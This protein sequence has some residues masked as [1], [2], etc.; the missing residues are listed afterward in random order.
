MSLAHSPAAC[1]ITNPTPNTWIPLPT[2]A[3]PDIEKGNLQASDS[4]LLDVLVEDGADEFVRY[5][6]TTNGFYDPGDPPQTPDHLFPGRLR[7]VDILAPIGA[8]REASGP[9]RLAA[10]SGA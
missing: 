3:L 4:E 6:D 8:L 2:A 10:R 1:Q 5:Y 9:S 7:P